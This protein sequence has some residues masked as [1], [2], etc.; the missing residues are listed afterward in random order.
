ME[1]DVGAE[2]VN[3]SK[4]LREV[5][6]NVKVIIGDEDSSLMAAINRNNAKEKNK[7]KIFKLADM[8][9]VK[10]NLS[11]KLYS[12]KPKYKVLNIKN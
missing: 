1:A 5:N 3:H 4:I 2:I 6:V 11:K 12:I 7:R 8:N 10:K 9:H